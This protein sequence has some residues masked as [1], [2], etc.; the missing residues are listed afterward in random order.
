MKVFHPESNESDLPQI[1][2]EIQENSLLSP[3]SALIKDFIQDFSQTILTNKAMRSYPDLISLAYWFRKSN[4]TQLS[5]EFDD[6]NKG[7][8][9]LPRGVILHFAP[10]NITTLFV[11]SWFIS[12]LMGNSNI[13][14]V[15]SKANITQD[16]LLDIIINLLRK[17]EYLPIRKRQCILTYNYDSEITKLLS[18]YCDTRVIWGGDN[19]IKE[20]RKIE[21]PPHATEMVFSDKFS[22]SILS[23]PA[24]IELEKEKLI[25]LVENFYNDAYWFNQRGCSSPKAIVWIGS[26]DEVSQAQSVFWRALNKTVIKNEKHSVSPIS[27]MQQFS[28]LCFYATKNNVI[29]VTNEYGFL[30]KRVA[31]SNLTEDLKENHI[32][33]GIFL[34]LTFSSLEEANNLFHYKDQTL[35]VFGFEKD[36]LSLIIKKLNKRGIDRIVPIGQALSFTYVWDGVNLMD[37]FTR[38]IFI[39]V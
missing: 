30:P 36:E 2:L 10:S 23:A 28:A 32:G 39:G 16:I 20:I 7:R 1:F 27:I 4:I 34:E 13:I 9:I 38:E 21:V 33:E 3:F 12:L 35:T 29:S 6:R 15:S 17:D 19:T 22:Y 24:I 37:N 8:T 11:Y 26:K 5:S 18:S 31:I 25:Q 14:R